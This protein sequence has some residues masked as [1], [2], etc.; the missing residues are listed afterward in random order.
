MASFV[1]TGSPTL[2]PGVREGMAYLIDEVEVLIN[3]KTNQHHAPSD[4]QIALDNNR[5]EATLLPLEAIQT[6]TSAGSVTYKTFRTPQKYTHW[7]TT[8][9]LYD[10]TNELLSPETYDFRN[11]RF[12]FV[13]E[14]ARPVRLSG[15][16]YDVYGAAA[17]LL[18]QRATQLSE[19]FQ[20]F[21]VGN[22]QFSF[23]PKHR[24]VMELAK[25]YRKKQRSSVVRLSR[26]DVSPFR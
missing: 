24:G 15:F 13:D 1:F 25:Q 11:G 26:S 5:D 17:D 18:E 7:E 8:A 6:F 3:D 2:P 21:A 23:A 20:S 19:E 10:A 9:S 14:E 22:G 12:S 4:I 16:T